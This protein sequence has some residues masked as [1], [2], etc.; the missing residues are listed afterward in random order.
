MIQV[1]FALKDLKHL[2]LPPVFVR[3]VSNV[4]QE[5]LNQLH[6]M[7]LLSIKMNKLRLHAR[8]V[9]QVTLALIQQSRN[10]NRLNLGLLSTVMEQAELRNTVQ[11]ELSM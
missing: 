8:F 5:Q 2:S 11:Q 7:V 1:I 9:L 6:V 4:R 3:L 10:V